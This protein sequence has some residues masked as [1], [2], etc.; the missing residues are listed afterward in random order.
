MGQDGHIPRASGSTSGGCRCE[1]KLFS[2][3]TN[4]Q[5][6]EESSFPAPARNR[7]QQLVEM[8]TEE[9]PW[10]L[11]TQ[12]RR[13]QRDAALA[14]PPKDSLTSAAEAVKKGPSVRISGR[15]L[16][17]A[18]LNGRCCSGKTYVKFSLLVH[19]T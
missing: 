11:G 12:G 7:P 10:A 4:Q 18:S 19:M 15:K 8:L 16:V 5:R 14:V 1:R 3:V 9:R 6:L 2:E 17:R 13:P